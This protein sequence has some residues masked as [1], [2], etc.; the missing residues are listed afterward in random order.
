MAIAVAC[1]AAS[2][3]RLRRV[4]RVAAF[5]LGALS[6][7]LGRGANAARL[8]EMRDLLVAE[9]HSWE[10]EL[11]GEV[12]GARD[13]VERTALVNEQLGDL[14]ASLLWGARIP[15]VAARVS[16]MGPLF[17]VFFSLA[18]RAHIALTDIVAILGWGGAGVLCALA[19]GREA[20]RV[21]AVIRRN[22]DLW[23]GRILEAAKMP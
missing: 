2:F 7:A 10:G 4:H 5:D 16:V 14:E 6:T 18:T 3:E 23:V 15:V 20:D 13:T 19:T 17:F 21:A 9:A 22:I 11:L 1:V 12:L 8:A